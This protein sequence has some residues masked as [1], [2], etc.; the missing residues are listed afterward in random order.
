MRYVLKDAGQDFPNRLE[1]LLGFFLETRFSRGWPVMA[2]A[3]NSKLVA[4]AGINEPEE[5][6]WPESLKQTF[7]NLS[8][9]IGSDAIKRLVD[10]ED[11]CAEF[12]PKEAHYFLGIIGVLPD[13]Q[14]KGLAKLLIRDLIEE[15]INDPR[16]NG[17]CL[18][19]ENPDNVPIYKHLGFQVINEADIEDLHTWCMYRPDH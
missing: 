2:Y 19:T 13:Y 16:S 5:L 1:A 12:E 6:P 18:T 11:K 14:G 7:E 10:F 9:H 4:I 8:N 3:D 17:V 15:S